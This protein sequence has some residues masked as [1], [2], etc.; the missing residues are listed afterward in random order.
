MIIVINFL[1]YN[2]NTYE[3]TEK[4]NL[5]NSCL[6]NPFISININKAKD[7]NNYILYCFYSFDELSLVE[8]DNNFNIISDI[9][10]YKINNFQL[11]KCN[12][13]YFS[14]VIYS[15]NSIIILLNCD[16]NSYLNKYDIE[17][18][19][20]DMINMKTNIPQSSIS[21]KINK[22][23]TYIEIGKFYQIK[24]DNYN[25]SISL[26]NEQKNETYIDFL[27]CKDKLKMF[28]NYKELIL[29]LIEINIDDDKLLNN[30]IN[31]AL[32]NENKEQLNISICE[33]EYILI[34]Y[35]IKNN[36]LL[37]LSKIFYF[38]NLG[39]N[40]FNSDDP[41]F[42]DICFPYSENGADMI[43]KDRLAYIYQNYSICEEG[44][45]YQKQILFK[46]HLFVIVQFLVNQ[47]FQAYL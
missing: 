41:F 13:N 4:N 19:Y 43:L 14:N 18:E 17:K 23:I 31:Y 2:I 9:D 5:V 33:E 22:I 16:G 27:T 28:Y 42:T 37:N 1:L 40:V 46:N 44:C 32:F 29:F 26:V 10:D 30:K 15:R 24:G 47:N 7:S 11:D 6:Y 39:I 25:I 35:K 21:T 34:H 36:S 12:N 38:D 3:F 8:L 20:I 45:T